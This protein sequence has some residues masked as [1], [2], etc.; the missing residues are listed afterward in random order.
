MTEIGVG[1]LK[2]KV[3]SGYRLWTS[4]ILCFTKLQ[5]YMFS[6]DKRL[7]REKQV[8]FSPISYIMKH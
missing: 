4:A 6:S 2:K 1:D 3:I 8:D 7:G 5:K